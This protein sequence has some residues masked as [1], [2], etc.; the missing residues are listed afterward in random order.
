MLRHKSQSV[1]PYRDTKNCNTLLFMGFYIY[2]DK[3][4]LGC[5]KRFDNSL[6]AGDALHP[7]IAVNQ[8]TKNF[9]TLDNGLLQA[10]E[11]LQ[12]PVSKGIE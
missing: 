8:G 7:A 11:L 4:G 2:T 1:V 3:D 6:R 10:G 5:S 9:Y 12:I